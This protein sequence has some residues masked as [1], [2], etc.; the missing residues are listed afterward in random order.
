MVHMDYII[1]SYISPVLSVGSGGKYNR[2]YCLCNLTQSDVL[3]IIC[4]GST[5]NEPSSVKY[6]CVFYKLAVL[7]VN[8][9]KLLILLF[10][11]NE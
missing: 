10:C 7:V 2:I 9:Y 8:C 1:I 4:F 5:S 3:L 11:C 6:A